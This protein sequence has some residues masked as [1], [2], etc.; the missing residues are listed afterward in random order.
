[1]SRQTAASSWPGS[2]I[3]TSAGI[4]GSG[5]ALQRHPRAAARQPPCY[6]RQPTLVPRADDGNFAFKWSG[7]CTPSGRIGPVSRRRVAAGETAAI[8]DEDFAGHVISGRRREPHDERAKFLRAA[9]TA[10][11]YESWSR[12]GHGGIVGGLGGDETGGHAVRRHTPS[13]QAHRQ[14]PCQLG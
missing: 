12:K 5:P 4:V 11:G 10:Y 13:A 6:V 14:R 3:S 1:M 9:G 7:H 2:S 8:D